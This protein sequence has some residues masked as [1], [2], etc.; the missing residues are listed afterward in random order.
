MTDPADDRIK[1]IYDRWSRLEGEKKAISDDLKE[2][3]S[4]AK[5]NGYDTKA[6]RAAFRDVA[7]AGDAANQEHQALVDL[8]VD[9]LTRDARE[10]ARAA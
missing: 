8:Y 9:A 3:F 10:E 4:E 1:S 5:S 2:L 7:K 6:L